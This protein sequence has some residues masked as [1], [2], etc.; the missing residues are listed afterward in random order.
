LR[1]KP[2]QA[3][4]SELKIRVAD[5]SIRYPDA[6][7]VCTPVSPRATVVS[8]PVVI[9]EIISE[10]SATNDLVT[11]NAEYRETG[12]VQ[13]YVILQQTQAAAMMF[14]RKGDDWVTDWRSGH[15][16]VLDLPEIGLVIPLSELYQGV[17]FDSEMEPGSSA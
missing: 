7:V 12:S 1:S 5:H 4:G 3:Y 16:G 14:S 17:D 8:D 11:K 15:D 13:R 10:S 9:F 2:S 6:F